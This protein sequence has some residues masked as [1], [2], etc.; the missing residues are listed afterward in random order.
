MAFVIYVLIGLLVGVIASFA[1]ALSLSG[2]AG[3]GGAAGV[4]GGVVANL[5]FSDG[6]VLDLYGSVGAAILALVAVLTISTRTEKTAVVVEETVVED[7][8]TSG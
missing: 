6:I 8:S 3:V 4:V 7:D 1:K 2:A 5:I